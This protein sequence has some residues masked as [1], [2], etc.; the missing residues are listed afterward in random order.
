[1]INPPKGV[2][3]ICPNP[4]GYERTDLNK[5]KTQNQTGFAYR[6]VRDEQ[7]FLYLFRLYS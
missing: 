5:A 4:K 2:W 1:M 3:V 6:A 7:P